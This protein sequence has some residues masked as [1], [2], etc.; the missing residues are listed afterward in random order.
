MRF[1]LGKTK[2]RRL[3]SNASWSTEDLLN[4]I[5]EGSSD[6]IAA[7]DVDF[8]YLV[9][10]R[11]YEVEFKRVFGRDLWVGASLEEVFADS[12]EDRSCLTQM[13]SR[14][15][16]GEEFIETRELGD[17][18]RARRY[19][20]MC[21]SPIRCRDGGLIGAAS[22]IR[23]VTDRKRMEDRLQRTQF[24][25]DRAA[26]PIFWINPEG[27]FFY[28]NEAACRS[29]GYSREELLKMSVPDI[30]PLVPTEEWGKR[31]REL[32][33]QAA[34]TF[35]SVHRRKSG[36]LFPVE[37]T[38]NYQV[39]G[40]CE[41]GYAFVRDISQRKRAEEALRR[42]NAELARSNEELEQ[43]ASIVSHDLRSPMLTI[44]GYV[45]LLASDLGERLTPEAREAL[46]AIRC[47]ID[48]MNELLKGLLSYSRVGRG[49]VT[50]GEC[51]TE[52]VLGVVLGNLTAELNATGAQVTH[53][54]LP[55]V[56][57]DERLLAQL[58]Q[59][60]VEN[61]IK[62]RSEDPPHVH[63]SAS[64]RPGE[65]ILSVA[66][67]GIGVPPESRERIFGMFQRLQSDESVYGGMG[68]GLATCKKIVEQH[69]GR[70]WV[71]PNSPKG[72][73]FRF[74]LP[75]PA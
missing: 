16:R 14:A 49:G 26:D 3:R 39:H 57:A 25:V 70:I 37:I 34:C 5:I 36:E 22:I 45:F 52:E 69:G 13:W 67:N 43:F 23:D 56:R 44:S 27:R 66:D 75:R 9:F 24:A 50:L 12:P 8:R 74:T 73:V 63:V 47:T 41:F 72:S 31:W 21:F 55:A 17:P 19:Y 15:L 28:V 64:K 58:L 11:A 38:L 71:E 33:E 60:L 59:N 29:L 1:I 40:G 20:E 46:G 4:G 7:L 53:D 62:Y 30:D 54:P 48:Q 6:L 10:N 68:I 61:A 35:E 42:A 2:S 65:W 18:G 32:M 51:N